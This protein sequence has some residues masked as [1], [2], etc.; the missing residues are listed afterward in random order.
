MSF[1]GAWAGKDIICLAES[2]LGSDFSPAFITGLSKQM[3]KLTVKETSV[4]HIGD[5]HHWDFEDCADAPSYRSD[6]YTHLRTRL[7]N[8]TVRHELSK[9]PPLIS[10]HLQS[11]LFPSFFRFYPDSET[12]ILRN[13]T[14]KEFV[15]P[16]AIAIDRR[17]IRGPCIKHVGFGHALLSRISLVHGIPFPFATAA[18]RFS[19]C[20]NHAWVGHC[21]DITTLARHLYEEKEG[22]WK[23]VSNEVAKDISA[24]WEGRRGC[25]WREDILA[26]E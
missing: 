15:L 3:S 25:H 6:I 2:H 14:T 24:V 18:L 10:T 16:E 20:M 17:F 21:F 26:L 5:F 8:P 4:W 1:L 22:E 12:Y 11:V 19:E 7:S 9:M 23:D 13:L